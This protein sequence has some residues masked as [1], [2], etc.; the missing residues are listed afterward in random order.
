[1]EKVIIHPQVC[2]MGSGDGEY[3]FNKEITLDEFLKEYKTTSNSWGTITIISRD[4]KILR[5]FDYDTYN[6]SQFFYHLSW[7]LQMKIKK[8]TFMYCW[9]SEDVIIYLS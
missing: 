6:N 3:K 2:D 4:G 1:M 8:V 9:M 5:K 7:E